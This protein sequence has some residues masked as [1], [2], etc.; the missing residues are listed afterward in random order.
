[1][2][3]YD[4]LLNNSYHPIA[5]KMINS[6]LQKAIAADPNLS[7]IV[8]SEADNDEDATEAVQ[9]KEFEELRVSSQELVGAEVETELL[10]PEPGALP[11]PDGKQDYL[12]ELIPPIEQ[13]PPDV[14]AVVEDKP[15]TESAAGA[16]AE[17]EDS[18]PDF[19]HKG[20][21]AFQQLLLLV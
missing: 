14:S 13:L 1:M 17:E 10:S 2:I 8:E 7:E 5:R 20:T 9:T 12:W 11:V 19:G 18:K 6:D 16:V 21:I 3:V 4:P 15:F